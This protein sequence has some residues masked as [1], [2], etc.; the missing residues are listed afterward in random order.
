MLDRARSIRSGVN[1]LLL[2][3][4]L[5]LGSGPAQAGAAEMSEVVLPS[6]MRVVLRP[7]HTNPVVCSAVLVRAGVAWE[8]EDL[9]GASHFLEH[10]LFNGT[11]SRNQEQLYAD[12]DRIGAYNNATT[13]ADHTMFLLLA[14]KEHLAAALEIQADMLLHST[15]P[16]E[17]FEKEKGIVLEEMGRDV[18]NPGHLADTFFKSRLYA[19]S[20]YA[21]PVLGSVDSISGLSREA[22]LAYYKDRYVPRRMVLILAGDFDPNAALTIIREQFGGAG[23][24][25][26]TEAVA[27]DRSMPRATIPFE[28]EPKVAHSSVDAGRTYLR[29]AFPGPAEGDPDA[30]AFGLLTELLGGSSGPLDRAL[31]SG[32][33]PAVYDYSLYHDTTG[34]SGSLIFSAT[35]TGARSPEEVLRTALDTMIRTVRE[36]SLDPED[37]RLLREAGLTEEVTLAEQVHYYALF[38]APRFLQ[39]TVSQVTEEDAQGE[40]LGVEAFDRLVDRYLLPPKA[41]VTVSGPGEEDGVSTPVDLAGV[42][43]AVTLPEATAETVIL[44]NGLT[45]SVSTE[46]GAPVFGAHLIARNRSALEPEGRD[47]LADL[48]HHMLLEGTLARD[49]GGLGDELRGRGLNVKFHDNPRF[50]FDDYRTVPTYSFVMLET[51]AARA[52]EALRL[53]AEIIQTPRFDET[54]IAKTAAQMQDVAGRKE[55]SSSAISR[56]MFRSLV[57]PDHPYSRPVYGSVES[58]EGLSRD[59]VLEM[60]ARLFAPENLILTI[61]GSGSRESVLRRATEIFGGPGP[62][63]GWAAESDEESEARQPT[64]LVAAPPVGEARARAEQA[65]DKRQSY[66]R[67]GAVIDVAEDDRPALEAANLVLSDRLQMDLREQQGLAYSIGSGLSPL[68]GGRELLAIS[69]GT[70]PDN[71]ERAEEEI[72]RVVAELREGPVPGE[73]LE[74]IVAARKGRILMRR[75][76]R[77]NQAFYDGLRLLFGAPTGGDLEF[78]EALGQVTPEEVVKAARRYMNSDQWAVAIAR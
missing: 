5:W 63:G 50:P 44:Q 2:L 9:S 54:A 12:V 65:M 19:G 49:A 39:A 30:V 56:Q 62:G 32:S 48:V 24:D 51:R 69:M 36:R 70:A 8:A 58:F 11:E 15:L 76:P 20:P 77:Q 29:A 10:L 27:P 60:W 6:G 14:P 31:T 4:A 75:L 78:L 67:L 46:P 57:A 64:V 40:V 22:V 42:G 71:L 41:V 25:V 47:G 59:E 66:L 23:N 16:A 34:G 61:R 74:R 33:D 43:E 7:V 1:C 55:E 17:K 13:R 68:G 73:E 37:L 26:K 53:L 28:T 21:R 38:R 35:L 72:R 18:G 45:L 52:I 3:P